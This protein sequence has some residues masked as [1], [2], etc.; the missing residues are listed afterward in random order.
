M[1]ISY[2]EYCK[3]YDDDCYLVRRCYLNL[4]LIIEM[5]QKIINNSVKDKHKNNFHQQRENQRARSVSG[6]IQGEQDSNIVPRYT[7][8]TDALSSNDHNLSLLAPSEI[9]VQENVTNFKNL[10]KTERQVELERVMKELESLFSSPSNQ[11]KR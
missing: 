9:T 4:S 2:C 1:F 11:G 8:G 7:S 3:D 6:V 5:F 10:T